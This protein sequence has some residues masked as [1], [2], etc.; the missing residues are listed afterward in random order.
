MQTNFFAV[1]AKFNIFV[2]LYEVA[3]FLIFVVIVED[4]HVPERGQKQR[5]E[6]PAIEEGWLHWNVYVT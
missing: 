4:L 1:L 2:F 5:M 6:H 3:E